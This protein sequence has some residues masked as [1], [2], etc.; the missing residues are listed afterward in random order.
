MMRAAPRHPAKAD[1]LEQEIEAALRPGIFINYG[2]G[3]SFVEGL[4]RLEDKIAKLVPSVPARAVALYET[5]LAGCYEKV[6]ELDDSPRW[7][8]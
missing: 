6:E 8:R 4:D 3:W 2:A 5:F 1:P 7:R